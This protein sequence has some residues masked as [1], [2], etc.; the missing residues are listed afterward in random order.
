MKVL[1]DFQTFT[2]QRYG[3]VSRYF[4]ELMEYFRQTGTVNFD[5]GIKHTRNRYLLGGGGLRGQ[6]PPLPAT[7]TIDDFFGGRK[8]RGK[9]RLFRLYS[10]FSNGI[11]SYGENKSYSI[12]LLVGG[13]YDV[14]H[15]TYYEPYFLEL[16]EDKP[17]VVTVHDMIHEIFPEHFPLDD[18]TA[19]RKRRAIR[20]AD[21]IIAISGNTKN[22]IV[23]FVDIDPDRITVIP[24]ATNLNAREFGNPGLDLPLRFIA[25]VGNRTQYKNFYF[26][27]E[28]LSH[29]RDTELGLVCFGSYPFRDEEIAFFASRG[30]SR[31]LHYVEVDDDRLA[32]GYK[33]A[34][35]L[36]Y[37]SLYEGFGIP[38]IEAFSCGCP[39]I[40][41]NA[42]SF[43]EVARDAAVYFEPKDIS[44]LA[45]AIDMV[46]SDDNLRATLA[47][48]GTAVA[49]EYSYERTGEATRAV[50][51]RA[52]AGGPRL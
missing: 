38:I 46:A 39:V 16:I 50:Y 22:D 24:H 32:E 15:P 49:G 2:L 12:E 19:E 1:Y 45:G 43:P 47:T 3:G 30:V 9:G 6:L 11:D 36:V 20:R 21:Q 28:A 51:E 41:S 17:L 27:V 37:P 29:A 8:F 52:L 4:H 23:R 26:L 7:K 31:R 40:C 34:V 33:R 44:G 48:R 13:D 42:S 10:G 25:Y 5:L 14:F 35:A 18:G